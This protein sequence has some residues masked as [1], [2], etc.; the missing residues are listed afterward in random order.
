M[1]YAVGMNIYE[2][3]QDECKS[4][5]CDDLGVEVCVAWQGC[6][7]EHKKQGFCAKAAFLSYGCEICQEIAAIQQEIDSG[8]I[9]KRLCHECQAVF[10][11]ST[12]NAYRDILVDERIG[13]YFEC[14]NC[15]FE[16]IDDEIESFEALAELEGKDEF[17]VW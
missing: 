2:R 6:K 17:D 3:C 13:V 5:H 11:L 1:R 16:L 15:A 9:P 12:E 14:L 8:V 7:E 4:E 10:E